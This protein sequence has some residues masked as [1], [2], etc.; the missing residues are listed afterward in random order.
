MNLPFP[1][2]TY[3][4]ADKGGDSD[5]LI[6]A[7]TPDA[8]VEDEGRFHAGHRAIKAW[9]RDVKTRYRHV[10]EPLDVAGSGDFAK[11]RARVT[12]QFPGSPAMLTFA[13]RLEGSRI[14]GLEIGA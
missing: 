5:A 3:F 2:Q 10:I 4:D 14:A 11:V 1:I 13:F 6:H 7:F 9:W 12:G 8:V